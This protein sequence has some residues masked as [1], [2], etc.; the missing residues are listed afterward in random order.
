MT[1]KKKYI[2]KPSF[3]KKGIHSQSTKSNNVSAKHLAGPVQ[4]LLS[5]DETLKTQLLPS[6]S[7]D[8]LNILD[9]QPQSKDKSKIVERNV[10]DTVNQMLATVQPTE[11]SKVRI[12]NTLTIEKEIQQL[13]TCIET[14]FHQL[15]VIAQKLA[16]SDFELI[17]T[18]NHII[19][20][21]PSHFEIKNESHLK[22]Q[23]KKIKKNNIEDRNRSL[24]LEKYSQAARVET[25]KLVNRIHES[26]LQ[27][28]ELKNK[29]TKYE[30]LIAM[31][32]RDQK[33]AAQKISTLTHSELMLQQSLQERF[34]E[35]ATLTNL[36]VENEK[37]YQNKLEELRKNQP[38]II[39]NINHSLTYRLKNKL[40]TLKQHKSKSQQ[41]ARNVAIIRQSE[42]F[43][44]EWYLQHYP[45]ASSHKYG[46]AGHYLENGVELKTNPSPLFDGNWYLQTYQDVNDSGMN[47]LFHYIKFGSEENRLTK[48]L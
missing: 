4:S 21:N 25:E 8:D 36:F 32:E 19:E 48:V 46:A 23:N 39:S 6:V 47:P 33:F 45:Q 13:Q 44:G 27:I 28:T 43:D 17:Q 1:K 11:K 40:I 35:L 15:Q 30:D 37:S 22:N 38:L 14:S 16:L 9:Q 29:I 5:I 31:L 41:F 7:N 24:L 12:T 42:L 3:N 10:S 20:E 34:D 2:S 26:D 18:Q